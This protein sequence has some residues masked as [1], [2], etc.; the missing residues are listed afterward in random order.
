MV[1]SIR[2]YHPLNGVSMSNLHS[3]VS[4]SESKQSEPT[5]KTAQLDSVCTGMEAGS[6]DGML[7]NVLVGLMD[8]SCT[9]LLLRGLLDGSEAQ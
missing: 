6:Y 2:L 4:V 1:V 9:S 7:N 5:T 3:F 8:G